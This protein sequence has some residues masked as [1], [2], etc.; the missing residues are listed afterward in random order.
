MARPGIPFLGVILAQESSY[1]NTRPLLAALFSTSYMCRCRCSCGL[2]LGRGLSL[3]SVVEVL[4]RRDG[5][6]VERLEGLGDFVVAVAGSLAGVLAGWLL[7]L[8]LC[9]VPLPR[10]D[11]PRMRPGERHHDA[12]SHGGEPSASCRQ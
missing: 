10:D 2:G 5:A 8:L 6:V 12:R 7:L 1:R 4:F 11:V 9:L 3:L